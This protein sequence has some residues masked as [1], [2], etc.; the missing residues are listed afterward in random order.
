MRH[1]RE[2]QRAAQRKTDEGDAL[3]FPSRTGLAQIE[4]GKRRAVE[5]QQGQVMDLVDLDQLGTP[6]PHLALQ[7]S[8]RD[9]Q[10]AVECGVCQALDDMRVGD[11]QVG[12]ADDEPGSSVGES[13]AAGFLEEA[14]RDDCGLDPLDQLRKR[15]GRKRPTGRPKRREDKTQPA[16]ASVTRGQGHITQ[17]EG[18]TPMSAA[19]AVCGPDGR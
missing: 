7:L 9:D 10:I 2:P 12:V 15:V 19:S 5:A 8:R 6:D 14:H 17:R 4:P 18:S 13:R 1:R 16:P 11:R 3:S